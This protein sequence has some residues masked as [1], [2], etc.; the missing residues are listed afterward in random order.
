MKIIGITGP[1]AAGK[2]T[3][4]E[5]LVEKLGFVHYG[6]SEFLTDLVLEA[7]QEVNRDTMRVVADGL[8]AQFGPSYVIEQL[9]LKAKVTGKDAIIESVRTV[10][11]IERMRANAD[12]LLLSVDANQELR[13]Q[14]ALKRGSTKDNISREKFQEQEALEADNQD[15][16][17]GNIKACQHLA[18]IHLEN[19]GT[20]EELYAQI[21]CVLKDF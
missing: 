17:K 13:Y 12:F 16:T 6:A 7:G 14:R 21:D 10:G 11:E 1:A 18:D 3:V 8:R 20:R 4:V 2:G 5:Y 19:N 9:Y 15:T